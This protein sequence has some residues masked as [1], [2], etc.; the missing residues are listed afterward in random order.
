MLLMSGFGVLIILLFISSIPVIAVFIW[1]RLARYP[2]S[3]PRFSFSLLAGAVS[4]FSALFLQSIFAD[5]N[6]FFYT[7]GKWGFIAEIF[8]RIAFTE[9]FSRLIVLIILL[10]AI[11]WLSSAK[12]RDSGLDANISAV[13]MASA[14]GLIAGLG[15]AILESAVYGASNPGN[16]LLRTFTAAPLH[17][18]CGF[19]A[20]SSVAM[21][22]ER[23]VSAILRFLS[24]IVIHGI[25]NFM[26][27][28]PG[29]IPSIAA[30]LIALSALAS[31]LLVIRNGMKGENV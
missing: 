26:L 6:E 2:F 30:I 10:S 7:A 14:S 18:A 25:Y 8:V 11:R 12:Q 20:G 19:R 28:I 23:P 24:A 16:A 5:K 31:S 3:L 4:F 1:F 21:F 27:I 22:S 29:F 15:F 17:G 9:E 13:T